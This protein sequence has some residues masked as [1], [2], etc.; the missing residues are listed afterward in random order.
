MKW[1]TEN[2]IRMTTGLSMEFYVPWTLKKKE[3]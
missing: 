2:V 1:A 3:V